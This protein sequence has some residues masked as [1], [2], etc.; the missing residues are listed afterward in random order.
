MSQLTVLFPSSFV[1][2]IIMNKRFMMLPEMVSWRH[3]TVWL[4]QRRRDLRLYQSSPILELMILI[5]E[6]LLRKPVL[7]YLK[8]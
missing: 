7:K 4:K 6:I 3:T 1:D 2:R 5:Q 8:L